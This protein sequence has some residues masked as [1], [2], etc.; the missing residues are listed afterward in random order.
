MLVSNS[1]YSSR[2]PGPGSHCYS[3]GTASAK[4]AEQPAPCVVRESDSQPMDLVILWGPG[5]CSEELEAIKD[6]AI[7]AELKY[8][9]IET[10]SDYAQH[11]NVVKDLYLNNSLGPQTQVVACFASSNGQVVQVSKE[12][13]EIPALDLI[14]ALRTPPRSDYGPMRPSWKGTIHAAWVKSGKMRDHYDPERPLWNT[15]PTMTHSCRKGGTDHNIVNA[16]K[17]LCAYIGEVKGQPAYL[18]PEYIAAR[19]LGVTGDTF[20]CVGG[21]FKRALVVGAPRT[22]AQAQQEHLIAS[23]EVSNGEQARIVGARKDLR[24]LARAMREPVVQGARAQRQETKVENVFAERAERCQLEAMDELLAQYPSLLRMKDCSGISGAQIYQ[25]VVQSVTICREMDILEAGQGDTTNLNRLLE[26]IAGL[27]LHGVPCRLNLANVLRGQAHLLAEGL[28]WT[29]RHD[30]EALFMH[31]LPAVDPADKPAL[32]RQCLVLALQTSPSLAIGILGMCYP[33][34]TPAQLLGVG[35]QQ[36][37]T[38]E[39]AMAWL[40]RIDWMAG[41][42]SAAVVLD[43]LCETALFP[44]LPVLLA[45][46]YPAVFESLLAAMCRDKQRYISYAEA[47]L[48]H[49]YEHRDEALFK[50]LERGYF[51]ADRRVQPQSARHEEKAVQPNGADS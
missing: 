11:N 32:L 2:T 22:S 26:S 50:K 10:A 40:S 39:V 28:R 1:V 14:C 16:I 36:G 46:D 4:A 51:R 24:A 21:R 33:S 8:V 3:G 34:A 30:Q 6:A 37:A 43:A 25:R 9:V 44:R 42:H 31:L 45:R 47:L 19:M 27:Y 41:H 23:L 35:L 49:A 29:T 38:Q 18:E 15:G 48:N 12:G 13:A 20:A 5:R 7:N 17:D